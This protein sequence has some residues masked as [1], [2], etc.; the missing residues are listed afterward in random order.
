[1][2]LN[3]LYQYFFHSNAEACRIDYFLTNDSLSEEPCNEGNVWLVISIEGDQNQKFIV[4]KPSSI[5]IQPR[6]I[7]E[8][9]IQRE[10]INYLQ[11]SD[12]SIVCQ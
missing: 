10:T 5:L 1:M 3:T 11:H 2:Q 7:V 12:T 4:S 6:E 9:I 8:V